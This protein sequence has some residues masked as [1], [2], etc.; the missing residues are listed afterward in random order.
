M[1]AT[2]GDSR[3]DEVVT[4]DKLDYN[5]PLSGVVFAQPIGV[6]PDSAWTKNGAIR[7]D[8]ASVVSRTSSRSGEVWRSRRRRVCGKPTR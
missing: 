8:G 6:R 2:R 4:I 7:S 3:R 1:R 5:W